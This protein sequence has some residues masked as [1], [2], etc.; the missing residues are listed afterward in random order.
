MLKDL[1]KLANTLDSKG[2]S[3]EASRL[4]QILNKIGKDVA[5][6]GG[7]TQYASFDDEEADNDGSLPPVGG[8][9]GVNVAQVNQQ[10]VGGSGPGPA[11]PSSDDSADTGG[12][13]SSR[14]APAAG[15]SLEP[16][17]DSSQKVVYI[18]MDIEI[19]NGAYVGDLARIPYGPGAIEDD[20][21]AIYDIEF[22]ES[23]TLE[24]IVSRS[25]WGSGASEGGGTGGSESAEAGG[26]DDSD[27][28]LPTLVSPEEEDIPDVQP[29]QA[30]GEVGYA[31]DPNVQ[32]A[33]EDLPED[34]RSG[35]STRIFSDEPPTGPPTGPREGEEDEKG[36][37]SLWD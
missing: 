22:G 27:L 15:I 32:Q 12:S 24:Q 25:Y 7:G 11:D 1:I 10:S 30:Q 28:P 34:V 19:R 31:G 9:P 37:G 20:G 5:W 8:P 33:D 29:D 3:K 4:D 23:D 17:I 6:Q 13:D 18:M 26:G 35:E 2:L 21:E 36:L 16:Y 14:P